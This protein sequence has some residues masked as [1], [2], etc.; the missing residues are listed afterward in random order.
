MCDFSGK[1][2]AW[3]DGELADSE[4]APVEGHIETCAECRN[5]LSTYRQMSSAFVAYCEVA[6]KAQSVPRPQRWL[7]RWMFAAAGA[8]AAVA[9]LLPLVPRHGAKS[10]A[11][12]KGNLV[13]GASAGRLLAAAGVHSRVAPLAERAAQ[14]PGHLHRTIREARSAADVIEHPA[15]SV[16]TESAASLPSEPAIQI[17]IPSDAI[18]PAG[19]VPEGVNFVADV[20]LAADGTAEGLRLQPSLVKFERRA[21]RP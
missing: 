12:D 16:P 15:E 4:A 9:L 7:P 11:P 17:A 18:F 8:A 21:T 20:T 6:A 1:L 19:A 14:N 3:M 10:T 13:A 2:I 5:R